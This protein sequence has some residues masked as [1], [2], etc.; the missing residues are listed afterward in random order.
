LAVDDSYTKLLL[1]M[2]GTDKGTIFT[3]EAG[4]TVTPY[5]D[6]TTRPNQNKHKFG[7]AAGKFDG[8]GDDYLSVP[9]SADFDLGTGDFTVDCWVYHTNH[10]TYNHICTYGTLA[11]R[12][13]AW[14]TKATGIEF[15]YT[16]NG[17][18]DTLIGV[19]YNFSLNILYHVAV[20]R[21]G[22]KIYFFVD[23]VLL[24]SGGT[25]FTNTIYNAN[26][27]FI[28]GRFG[29]YTAA[30]HSFKGYIDEF[31]LTKG[32]AIWTADFTL[33]SIEYSVGAN[34]KLLL[35]MNGEDSGTTFTD[36]CGKTVTA[37]GHAITSRDSGITTT[38]FGASAGAILS[39]GYLS[40]ADSDDWY[41]GTGDFTVD[42][43]ICFNII[44]GDYQFIYNQYANDDDRAGLALLDN[45]T[46]RLI[47]DG[48]TIEFNGATTIAAGTLYHIALVRSGNSWKMF[49]NGTQFGDTAT[50]SVS[51]DN[52]TA[53]L[54]IGKYK[55][56]Y[57]FVNAFIDEFRWSKGIAR[58]TTD[59]TPPTEEYAPSVATSGII[60][61]QFI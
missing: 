25:S 41:L 56:S 16:T 38:K 27:A 40:I 23:G 28:I 42:C 12:G 21:T 3:D 52:I 15:Y 53:P 49:L 54:F 57:Y 6:V 35:H 61:A 59:F 45:N 14:R 20:T 30:D 5:G 2:D 7:S 18:G 51:I 33:P 24:N 13:W 34:T 22:G 29:N 32:E 58:W 39:G 26:S 55:D 36:E 10:N 11:S 9:Q 17:S 43:W 46:F 60:L 19:N 4:K 47:I 50:S 8:N 31:R 37:N 44:T 1:H 48:T